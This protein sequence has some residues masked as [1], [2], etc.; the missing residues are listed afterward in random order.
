MKIC[1]LNVA[2]MNT[3]PLE[4]MTPEL[5][6]M[7]DWM[8]TDIK[9]AY[10]AAELE[11]I[12]DIPG[13]QYYKYKCITTTHMPN[14]KEEFFDDASDWTDPDDLEVLKKEC[15]KT[16]LDEMDI[17]RK[18][19]FYATMMNLAAVEFCRFKGWHCL[20]KEWYDLSHFEVKEK[21]SKVVAFVKEQKIDVLFLQELTREMYDLIKQS[22]GE[23]LVYGRGAYYFSDFVD[24]SAIVVKDE[25]G[26]L[27]G[28]YYSLN[29]EN[30]NGQTAYVDLGNV[31]WV[32]TH[33]SGKSKKKSECKNY[34]DQ[35]DQLKQVVEQIHEFHGKFVCVGGD[36][37]Q[38]LSR[39]YFQ[40]CSYH[41]DPAGSDNKMRTAMQCQLSK[42]HKHSSAVKDGFIMT[43]YH[44][45]VKELYSMKLNG[46]RVSR[47][48]REDHFIPSKE[49]PT[50]H[51]ALVAEVEFGI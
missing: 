33:F 26:L 15:K 21:A 36:F 4:F 1:T 32:S 24:G 51:F 12:M 5:K 28:G 18:L 19:D 16:G 49:H 22:L 34:E 31:L 6:E 48:D 50:D 13:E 3:K 9:S 14:L 43:R 27:Y 23:E 25:K 11:E 35:A 29:L 2:G 42:V 10:T 20:P 40:G 44:F 46:E 7:S 30:I 37:N 38:D 8:E 39:H 17:K 41:T 47:T 45:K